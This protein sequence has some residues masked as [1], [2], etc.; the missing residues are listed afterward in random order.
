MRD[1]EDVKDRTI[2]LYSWWKTPGESY[3][4]FAV[5]EKSGKGI[6]GK[7]R[8]THVSLLEWQ[9]ETPVNR[10]VED[11][12]DLV[13]RGQLIQIPPVWEPGKTYYPDAG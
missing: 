7:Y 9:K 1:T 8:T 5:V 4:G 13:D 6:N 2:P 11:F 12:W 3:R 10:S